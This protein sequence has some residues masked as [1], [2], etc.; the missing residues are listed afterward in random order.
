[1]LTRSWRNVVSRPCGLDGL[2]VRVQDESTPSASIELDT[3]TSM[4]PTRG[5]TF[6]GTWLCLLVSMRMLVVENCFAIKQFKSCAFY[7]L[8]REIQPICCARY[9]QEA[10]GEPGSTRNRTNLHD[11]SSATHKLSGESDPQHKRLP[12]MTCTGFFALR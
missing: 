12:S 10:G 3:I 8:H 6:G 9:T 4:P 7:F 11:A 2:R 1:M 5:R